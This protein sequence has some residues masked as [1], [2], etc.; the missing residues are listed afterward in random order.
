MD[1]KSLKKMRFKWCSYTCSL[2]K[3]LV[4]LVN[5]I[6]NFINSFIWYYDVNLYYENYCYFVKCNSLTL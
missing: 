6:I 1:S 2:V 4:Q 5:K 3:D